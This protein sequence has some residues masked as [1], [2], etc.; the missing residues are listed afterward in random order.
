MRKI[1]TVTLVALIWSVSVAQADDTERFVGTWVLQN[2]EAQSADGEWTGIEQWGT[3]SFGIIMYDSSGNMSVQIAF[4][5]RNPVAND[6][7]SEVVN[8]YVA[9]AGAYDVDTT[10]GTVT[11]HRLLH[12]NSSLKN[13]T[14]VR[15]YKIQ[16]NT[17]TLTVAPDRNIRLIWLRQDHKLRFP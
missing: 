7:T 9:Y 8:G 15:F 13:Q 10:E 17:L 16:G 12:I 4:E 2:V 11:H 5:D 6:T 14:V 3:N 1:Q